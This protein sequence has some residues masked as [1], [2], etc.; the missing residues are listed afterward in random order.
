MIWG[1]FFTRGKGTVDVHNGIQCFSDSGIEACYPRTKGVLKL[2]DNQVIFECKSMIRKEKQYPISPRNIFIVNG[3]LY[4]TV[5]IKT[6]NKLRTLAVLTPAY[7]GLEEELA[8]A[9]HCSVE[10]NRIK[11]GF[12]VAIGYIKEQYNAL[13]NRGRVPSIT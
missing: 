11:K 10:P 4:S 3:T 2:I 7:N 13:F 5:K 1:L 6:N 9:L 8:T 12:R